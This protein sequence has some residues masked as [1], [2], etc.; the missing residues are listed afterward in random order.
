ML[1][2]KTFT[3]RKFPSFAGGLERIYCTHYYLCK[4][5]RTLQ[6]VTLGETPL[7]QAVFWLRS[8]SRLQKR[9]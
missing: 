8:L 9:C 4:Q 5:F 7:L 6:A 3:Q 1:T 2:S